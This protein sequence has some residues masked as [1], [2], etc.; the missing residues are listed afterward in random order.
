MQSLGWTFSSPN[1]IVGQAFSVPFSPAS[2]YYSYSIASGPSGA[3]I[4]ATTGL[5]IW[6]PT[7][8]DVGTANIVVAAS[9]GWGTVYATLSFPVY[10]TGPGPAVTL[11]PADWSSD[12]FTL[13][14]GSDGN[15]HV[16]LTGT[17][18]DVAVLADHAGKLDEHQ[19][20]SSLKYGRHT[21]HR[22]V[23]WEPNPAGGLTF[24]GP[25]G[26]IKTGFGVVILSGIEHLHGRH[27]GR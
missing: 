26:L 20:F 8:A 6:T 14:Q 25:G 3:S 17:T 10:V 5:L 13:T 24:S 12:G 11:T 15:V 7:L 9:N 19:Y 23:Q 16:Y 4:N 2:P 21:D 27:N 1:A 18:T 22:L